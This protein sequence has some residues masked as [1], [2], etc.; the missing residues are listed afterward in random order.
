[1]N[2]NY[3]YPTYTYLIGF[4]VTIVKNSTFPFP[5]IWLLLLISIPPSPSP[6]IRIYYQYEPYYSLNF[7]S[8]PNS[9]QF[10][11]LV[12]ILNAGPIKLILGLFCFIIF[13]FYPSARWSASAEYCNWNE[14]PATS[15]RR[16]CQ[17]M[18]W[19]LCPMMVIFWFLMVS[20]IYLFPRFS[21]YY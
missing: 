14:V 21:M 11:T 8:F 6:V 10:V 17:E 15:I 19:E 9:L 13:Q 20:Y 1:M 18:D 4:F 7:S 2:R 16:K 5:T 12:R 3:T